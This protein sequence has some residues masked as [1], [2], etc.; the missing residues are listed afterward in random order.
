MVFNFVDFDASEGIAVTW[1]YDSSGADAP[2]AY[3]PGYTDGTRE[4]T[5]LPSGEVLNISLQSQ[6]SDNGVCENM[7]QSARTYFAVCTRELYSTGCN[8]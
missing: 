8:F 6:Y 3:A 7:A 2:S 4:V 5:G 1:V